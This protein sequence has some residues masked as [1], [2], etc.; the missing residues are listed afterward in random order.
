[1]ISDARRFLNNEEGWTDT[2][3][4]RSYDAARV[5]LFPESY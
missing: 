1:M 3:Q 4:E 5:I 2:T